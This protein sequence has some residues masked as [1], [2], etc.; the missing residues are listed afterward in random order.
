MAVALLSFNFNYGDLIRWLEGEYTNTHRNWA[1]VS[2]AISAVRDIPP[3][4]GYPDLDYDR[5]FVHVLRVCL[6]RVPMSVPSSR[7]ANAI[8]MIT[9]QAWRMSSRKFGQNWLRRRCRVFMSCSLG[10]SGGSF[11]VF[12]CRHSSGC[13]RRI[14]V[15][16]ALTLLT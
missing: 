3:P 9:I 12:T 14:R 6:W 7:C 4:P 13:G 10:S 2:D 11:S 15:A 8:S 1:T 16:S 5:A